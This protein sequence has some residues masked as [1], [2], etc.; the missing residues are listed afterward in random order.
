MVVVCGDGAGFLD[1]GQPAGGPGEQFYREVKYATAE[2]GGQIG[3]GLRGA[4]GVGLMPALGGAVGS[5]GAIVLPA[6]A[7][8][9]EN[10]GGRG[11][12][13]ADRAGSAGAPAFQGAVG[14]GNAAGMM[15]ARGNGH[16]SS[17]RGG[18]LVMQ[19]NAVAGGGAVGPQRADMVQAGRQG[20]KRPG[21][22]PG[23]PVFAPAFQMVRRSQSA[24]VIE[25]AADGLK[26]EICGRGGNSAPA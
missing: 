13:L 22:R 21:V 26:S 11:Q 20:R 18:G 10:A 4:V 17:F 25:T 2:S 14:P 24:T 3:G 5:E 23:N 15:P 9:S 19:I 16:K 12:T 6:G 1:D 7:Q 8:G